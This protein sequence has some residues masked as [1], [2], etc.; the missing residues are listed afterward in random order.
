MQCRGIRPH[1]AARVTSHGF[2]QV[3][4]GTWDIFS[5]YGGDDPSK[6]VFV[7][8]RQDSFLVTRDTFRNLPEAWQGNTNASRGDA[9]D[10]GSLF[11]CHSDIG[12]PINFQEESA[13]ITF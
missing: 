4:A 5:S 6:L 7:Q 11:C 1:L 8:R 13:I 10:L 12:I 2:S 3:A 9:V